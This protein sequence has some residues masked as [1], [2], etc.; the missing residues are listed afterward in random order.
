MTYF[1]SWQYQMKLIH[2]EPLLIW[3]LDTSIKLTNH[4]A[5]FRPFQLHI[6]NKISLLIVLAEY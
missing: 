5:H 2:T 3:G 1:I 6:L 4:L